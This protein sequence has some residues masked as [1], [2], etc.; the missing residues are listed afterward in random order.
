MSPVAA[1]R[2]S[3]GADRK[4]GRGPSR[5][6][7]NAFLLSQLGA[8][9]T[10]LFSRLVAEVELSPAQAGLL[11][12]IGTDPGR[13]QQDIAEQLGTPPSRLVALADD[14]DQRGLIERTRNPND[15]RLYAVH[16]TD[17]GRSLL[18][19]LGRIAGRHDTVLLAAL[20]QNERAQLHE[21]LSRVAA[22]QGLVPG[23]HPGYRNPG[24]VEPV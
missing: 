5:G 10:Q 16:L 1:P 17:S 14:L 13:S 12:A 23:V 4:S 20:D 2:G 21:L 24:A 22:Q 11:R 3:V 7:T 8:H 15:R 6:P 19:S 9:A 18:G